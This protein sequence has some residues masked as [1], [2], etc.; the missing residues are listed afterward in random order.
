VNVF[1]V[2][3]T[4][5]R[6]SDGGYRA[7]CAELGAHAE[8]PTLPELEVKLNV[9]AKALLDEIADDGARVSKVIV[10]RIFPPLSDSRTPK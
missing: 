8:A 2:K 6:S 10:K 3:F 5:G 4:I 1:S 7:T 9:L